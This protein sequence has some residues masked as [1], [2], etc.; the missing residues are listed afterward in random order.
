MK[1]LLHCAVLAAAVLSPAYGMA[2]DRDKGE[3]LAL[4]LCARGHVVGPQ[5]RFGGIDSTPSFPLMAKLPELFLPRVR[6][7]QERRPHPQFKWD[8]DAGDI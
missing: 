3:A 4:R 2:A 7:F 5:N 1:R 6:R 8:I